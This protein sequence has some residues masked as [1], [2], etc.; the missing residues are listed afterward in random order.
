MST[1]SATLPKL[2]RFF[3]VTESIPFNQER[4]KLVSKPKKIKDFIDV[5]EQE[6]IVGQIKPLHAGETLQWQ[7]DGIVN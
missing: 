6:N 5:F 4:I 3:I 7:V 1:N 2:L